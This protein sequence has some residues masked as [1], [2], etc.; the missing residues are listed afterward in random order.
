MPCCQNN[1]T[2]STSE[3]LLQPGLVFQHLASVQAFVLG[4]SLLQQHRAICVKVEGGLPWFLLCSTCAWHL[5]ICIPDTAQLCVCTP[6]LHTAPCQMPTAC[7]CYLALPQR[8]GFWLLLLLYQACALPLNSLLP[9][10]LVLAAVSCPNAG[11][12]PILRHPA[13]PGLRCSWPSLAQP[14]I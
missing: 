11:C 7:S 4:P 8:R 14:S 13:C 9:T 10:A 6:R 3:I 2:L 12:Q 5:P 1:T